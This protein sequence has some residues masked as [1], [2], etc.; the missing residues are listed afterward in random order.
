M[1]KTRDIFRKIGNIKGM[2]CPK[3][4][5]I[6]DRKGRDL[7]EAEEI[8]K[9]WKEYMEELYK[10]DLNEFHYYSGIVSHPEPDIMENEFKWALRN[11]AINKPSRC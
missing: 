5:I 10:K 11:T 6:K 3:M 1:G 4:C 9:N 2:F 7:V 8:E